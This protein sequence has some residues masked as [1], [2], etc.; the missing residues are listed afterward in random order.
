MSES[1][2]WQVPGSGA[3]IY[4]TVFVPA[5]MGGADRKQWPSQ[6]RNQIE[7]ILDT[8]PVALVW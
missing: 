1:N 5:M 7:R 2:D 8:L 3:E 6:T 4:E